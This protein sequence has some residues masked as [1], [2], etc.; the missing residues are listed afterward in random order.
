MDTYERAQ[1]Y[2]SVLALAAREQKVLSYEMLGDLT[3]MAN[4]SGRELGHIYWYCLHHK[5]PLLNLLAVSKENGIPSDGCPDDLSDLPAKQ[6]RVYVYDWLKHGAPSAEDF[7][8]AREKAEEAQT[9]T[10]A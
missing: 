4:V 1:Q 8:R 5:L 9:A 3:G 7:K 2:W 6:A 10:A